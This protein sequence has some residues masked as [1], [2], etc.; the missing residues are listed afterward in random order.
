MA[1]ANYDA[2]MKKMGYPKMMSYPQSNSS[3]TKDEKYIAVE[4]YIDRMKSTDKN[5]PVVDK[6][7]QPIT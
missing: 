4:D 3:C 1:H 5:K 7:S 2:T 6:K